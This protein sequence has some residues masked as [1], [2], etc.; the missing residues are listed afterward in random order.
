MTEGTYEDLQASNSNFTKLLQSQVETKIVTDNNYSDVKNEN[1]IYENPN[2]TL[3]R[4]LSIKSCSSNF[5]G[6]NDLTN[7]TEIVE[8]SSSGNIPR[9]VYSSY[10]T[11]GGTIYKILFFTFICVFTQVLISW[12][13]LW[14]AYWYLC[15]T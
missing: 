10:I 15:K 5:R 6:C 8:T 2:F 9:S 3:N 11:A 12:T 4:Q 14:M 7:S 1:E 13:D